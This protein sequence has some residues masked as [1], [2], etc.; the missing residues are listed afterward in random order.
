MTH[1]LDRGVE[2]FKSIGVPPDPN[3][4]R[5]QGSYGPKL[6][7]I[8]GHVNKPCC[9]ELPLGVTARELIDEHGGGVWKGRKAKAVV[10]GGI[11]MGFLSADELDTPL[12]FE[13]PGQGRLP[14]PGHGGGRR[15]STTR[16][17]WSTCSTTA[18]GS[19]PTSRAASARRAARAPAG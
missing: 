14:R 5:D 16:R 12:D 18:A 8:S 15:R 4:P 3:N 19:C 13:R 11:S 6:Y 2:W 17:A 9:V 10:P 1:I 7:C